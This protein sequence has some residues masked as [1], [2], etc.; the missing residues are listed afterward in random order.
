M[1]RLTP[2]AADT[3]ADADADAVV[4]SVRQHAARSTLWN[5]GGETARTGGCY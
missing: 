4:A 5:A 2:A 1:M 3:D